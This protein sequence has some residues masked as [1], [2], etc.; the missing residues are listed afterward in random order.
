MTQFTNSSTVGSTS[1]ES[2]N[3]P[4]RVILNPQN[5]FNA[6]EQSY[7][8]DETW[9][10]QAFLIGDANLGADYG[11]DLV[12]RYWSS[13]NTKFTDTTL[14]GNIGINARP[15][16]TQYSDIPVKGVGTGCTDVN[17]Q[18][19]GGNYGMGRYYSEAIDDNA[20]TVYL[21]FGVPQFSSLLTFFNRAFDV[22]QTTLAR[23]G[24]GLSAWYRIGQVAGTIAVISAFPAI[25]S[26][27]IA[28]KVLS[29]FFTKPTSKFYTL[30][31]TMHTYWSA[32][33]MLTNT[34][35][36]NMGIL[37]RFMMDDVAN[38]EVNNPYKIDN[39]LLGQLHNMLPDVI[40]GE[41]GFDVFA[42]ANRAQRLANK[43]FME[44]Y[45]NLNVSTA[46]NYAGIVK[47]SYQEKVT[48]PGNILSFRN[49]IDKYLMFGYYQSDGTDQSNT[50]IEL[51]PKLDP[52]TDQT[53][54]KNKDSFLNYFDAEFRHGSQ[55]AIFKVDHTGSVSES[56]SNSVVE[57][58]ISNKF[59]S[60]S[61][62]S[63]EMR[64]SL[65]EGNLLGDTVGAVVSSAGDVVSGALDGMSLGVFGAIKGLLGSGYVDIPKHWQSSNASLPRST[66]SMQ[67]IS[68]YN[69]PISRMQNIFIP[70]AM[71]LA[72]TLPLSTGKQS[73]TSPFI[74][75]LFDRGRC[76]IQLGI[77]D[78]LSIT[79]GTCNLPFTNRGAVLAIDVSF[80]VMDLS[81]VLHMPI[82]TGSLFGADTTLD[83]DNILMDYLAVLAGQDIYSQIYQIPKAKLA[84][85]KKITQ[86][87]K[88]VSPAYWSSLI[89][90]E[91]TTGTL[92][93]I[94]PVGRI[95]DNLAAGTALV[96]RT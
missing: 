23:T 39:T 36:V 19:T 17:I 2:P 95:L 68:P 37:P 71:L 3:D 42:I 32:V 14:G 59:N 9:A 34:L 81:S 7:I 87:E 85:A 49:F 55:F 22:N 56:F 70:I 94:V 86:L 21:R 50:R 35:G 58:D 80:S 90:Q 44:E 89:H 38:Q 52:T 66:Y 62:S 11:G 13:A 43:K 74:C 4:N 10:K 77:I 33:N 75:Q 63:R 91:T 96:P 79:R 26:T 69:N 64:F 78:S 84:L 88:L 24:R 40:D 12:N 45:N 54:T 53:T 83:E 46:D 73:Y 60:M 92:S 41:N 76:Q 28:G 5:T 8:L 57:S 93:Y 25:S 31:P 47:K 18:N 51:D 1:V 67:L 15:Q 82:S 20:Q 72:G 48:P 65:G 29:A 27:I 30:K 6:D 61:S 16:F